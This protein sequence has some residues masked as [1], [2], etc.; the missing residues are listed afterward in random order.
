MP[1]LA[2]L[3]LKPEWSVFQGKR[4]LVTDIQFSLVKEG[5]SAFVQASSVLLELRTKL[6]SCVCVADDRLVLAQ[7]LQEV[8]TW[9]RSMGPQ[10]IS[11]STE[12]YDSHVLHQSPAATGGD[13]MCQDAS[14]PSAVAGTQWDNQQLSFI[15][16]DNGNID[17]ICQPWTPD[18]LGLDLFEFGLRPEVS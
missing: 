7:V 10:R 4:I 15:L 9:F 8:Q 18:V 13:T 2:V 3:N 5:W 1:N 16:G 6:Q 14:A 17:N 11:Q 12:G